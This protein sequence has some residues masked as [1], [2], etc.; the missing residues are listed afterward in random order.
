M[1]GEIT[2]LRTSPDIRK[3]HDKAI[4][5]KKSLM[6]YIITRTTAFAANVRVTMSAAVLLL[7]VCPVTVIFI[8]LLNHLGAAY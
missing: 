8:M 3:L 5:K 4:W 1:S 2:W 7:A 6:K